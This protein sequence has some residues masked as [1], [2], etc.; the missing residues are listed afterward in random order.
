MLSMLF[1]SALSSVLFAL[2]IS[3]IGRAKTSHVVMAGIL[4]AVS[5]MW[6]VASIVSVSR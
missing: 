2:F 4:A 3:S 1:A 5:L 6:L